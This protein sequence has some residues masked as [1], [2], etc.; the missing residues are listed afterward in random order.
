[1]ADSYLDDLE[2]VGF[3]HFIENPMRNF[4]TTAVYQNWEPMTFGMAPGIWSI[5]QIVPKIHWSVSQSPIVVFKSCNM[6]QALGI[7]YSRIFYPVQTSKMRPKARPTA[8]RHGTML[9]NGSMQ[10]SVLTNCVKRELSVIAQLS[11]KSSS[12]RNCAFAESASTVM[13]GRSPWS[14]C[15]THHGIHLLTWTKASRGFWGVLG[16]NAKAEGLVA[17]QFLFYLSRCI[18]A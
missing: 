10:P 14:M 11:N 1:M 8:P 4:P 7:V 2:T 3:K 17:E 9:I 12:H 13:S 18:F 15:R 5:T 6:L 16:Q